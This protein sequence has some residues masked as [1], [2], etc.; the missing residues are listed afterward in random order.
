MDDLP[1]LEARGDSDRL[2][3]CIGNLIGNAVKYSDDDA[4]IDVRDV[5]DDSQIAISVIDHGQGIPDDQQERI[6]QRFTRAEGVQLPKGQSST[7]LGLSI[8][9]MLMERMGGSISVSSKSGEGSRFS[10]YLPRVI[11]D[12]T[13]SI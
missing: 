4:P 7:G 12:E 5:Y 13:E 1:Y 8:V 11:E 2:I 9:K 3:Q 10:L 6:F